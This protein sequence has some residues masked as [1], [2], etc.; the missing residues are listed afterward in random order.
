MKN[1][2]L[3]SSSEEETDD[4]IDIH[5]IVKN[6]TV[7]EMDWALLKDRA[8]FL[9]KKDEFGKAILHYAAEL[10]RVDMVKLLL[11][12]GADTNARDRNEDTPLLL[13]CVKS[14]QAYSEIMRMF[15]DRP[16]GNNKVRLSLSHLCTIQ[17]TITDPF[18]LLG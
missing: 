12:H 7:E 4:E 3:E 10:G 8:S 15:I 17:S 18:L 2:Y 5:D 14:G 16:V 13:A 6:G 9:Y 11:R 1:K